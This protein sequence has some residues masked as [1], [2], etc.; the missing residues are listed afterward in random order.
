MESD[1]FFSRTLQE[2]ARVPV[3]ETRRSSRHHAIPSPGLIV[4]K[5]SHPKRD[6][7]ISILSLGRGLPR[8]LR[9]KPSRAHAGNTGFIPG[10]GRSH[11]LQSHEAH[12]PRRWNPCSGSWPL[13]AL[14]PHPAATEAHVPQCPR[15]P[16]GTT[17]TRSPDTQPQS[18]P[19]LH[20]ESTAGTAVKTQHTPTEIRDT[21]WF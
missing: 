12:R 5:L 21:P 14:S 17:A 6:A 11:V 18:G 10:Q 7:R 1:V 19:L 9:R 15:S 16:R 2:A 4:Q 20:G 13:R 8:R 3:C